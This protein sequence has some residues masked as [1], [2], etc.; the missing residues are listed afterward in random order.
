MTTTAVE[1]EVKLDIPDG[2][3][4]PDLVAV[5]GVDRVSD[6]GEHSLLATY[7]DTAD[8]RL[9]A[10]RATLRRRTGG[11]D[12]GWHLKLPRGTTP[13]GD[14]L[15]VRHDHRRPPRAVP[16]DLVALTRSRTRGADLTPV[17]ELATRRRAQHLHAPDGT[18]LAE[19]VLDEVTATPPGGEPHRWREVEVELVD[20]DAALLEAA[21]QVLLDAG[22]TRAAGP[23]KLGR[24]LGRPG[25]A[26]AD[27][28]SPGSVDGLVLAYLRAQVDALVDNDVR[29]RMG[30]ADGVHDMRVA[31]RRLRS[32]LATHRRRLD[33]A[34]TE[35][36]DE[37]KHL[38]TVLGAA[39]DAEVLGARLTAELADVPEPAGDAE[40]A[41]WVAQRLDD[42]WSAARGDLLATLDSDRYVEL[43]AALEA[44][45]AGER[46]PARSAPGKDP[47]G[48]RRSV[49]HDLRRVRRALR[50]AKRVR[51]TADLPPALHEVRKAA[52]RAR[53]A[54]EAVAPRVGGKASRFAERM[55][56]LQD[57]L[58]AHQDDV[59]ARAR[60][61]EL[62]RQARQDGPSTFPLGV[63]HERAERSDD[64]AYRASRSVLRDVRGSWPD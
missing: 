12:P 10:G 38:G 1:R 58:G 61:R 35:L 63:V 60:L 41:Q 5:P 16:E 57:L 21:V 53:Y 25:A 8:H 62:A 33:P 40:T 32:T 17:M 43:L 22:A 42:A 28:A 27:V 44:L 46:L 31:T 6:A 54:A 34:Q 2:W 45:V 59:V 15:E 51:G 20:G 47:R 14:R 55:E 50:D 29:V 4:L 23:S 36:R 39:R 19:V 13:G 56:R 3:E 52:K 24:A 37:L 26:R 7:H 11:T 9:L 64:A 49:R 18:V 48:K 30:T